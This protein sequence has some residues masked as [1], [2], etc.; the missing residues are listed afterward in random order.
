MQNILFFIFIGI[1]TKWKNISGATRDAIV[2]K[3]KGKAAASFEYI[4][5]YGVLESVF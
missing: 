4:E 1:Q 5:F 3:Y 2:I